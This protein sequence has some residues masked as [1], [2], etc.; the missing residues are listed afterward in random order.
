[1]P[2]LN[3]LNDKWSRE[4]LTVLAV[5]SEDKA[6]T[7][8]WIAQNE[9]RYGYAYDKGGKFARLCGVTGIPSSVL[10]DPSG[11]VVYFG[12]PGGVTNELVAKAVQGALKSPV[13]TL[14]RELSKVRA[15]LAK[16]DVA[17]AIAEVKSVA[18]KPNPPAEAEGLAESLQ[19]MLASSL[20]AATELG[21]QGNW[22]ECKR[23]CERLAKA[24]RGLPEE[25]A[26]KAKLSEIG[27]NPD[28]QKEIKAQMAL[29]RILAMPVR[30]EKEVEAMADSLQAFLKRNGGTYAARAAEAKL[31]D[32]KKA[33]Q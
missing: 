5:T 19:A 20:E 26:A 1:M 28:A 16:D 8:P 12:N 2:H 17:G 14:P 13:Y 23:A 30:K 32:L 27:R 10:V 25:A 31:Q 29:E 6:K 15:L 18:S 4:G 21:G 3:E 33:G 11:K 22:L 7:E 9:A 24:A